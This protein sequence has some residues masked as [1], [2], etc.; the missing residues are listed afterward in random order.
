MSQLTDRL[1]RE[2]FIYWKKSGI[3]GRGALT[4]IQKRVFSVYYNM[5]PENKRLAQEEWDNGET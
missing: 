4:L 3:E 2:A 5:T 1:K